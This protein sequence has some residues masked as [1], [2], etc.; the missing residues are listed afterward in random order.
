M[1]FYIAPTADNPAKPLLEGGKCGSSGL[2][3]A[4]LAGVYSILP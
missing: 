2:Q 3:N 1:L 4:D